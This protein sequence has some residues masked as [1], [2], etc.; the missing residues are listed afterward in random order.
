MPEP[1]P[2]A[3]PAAPRVVEFEPIPE[4]ARAFLGV[5]LNPLVQAASPLLLLMGQLRSAPASLDVS[6][7]RRHALDEIRRF[8]EQ[9]RRSGVRN[10]IVLAARYA[11]CAGLD[12]A[13]L[14][15]PS[16]SQ[17][18]WAQHPLLVALHREAWGGEKFFEMLDRVLVDPSRHI[19]LI[20]LQYLIL[21]LGFTGKYQMLERG[22]EKLADLQRNLHHA[23]RN[24]RGA[25]ASDLSLQW[26]GLEDQRN[27]LVRYVPWWVVV[28]AALVV[29]TIAFIVYYSKLETQAEPLHARLNEVG[30]G[31]F[32]VP[33]PPRPIKGPTLKQLLAPEEAAGLLLVTEE[34]ARTT[35]TFEGSELFRSGSAD[36]DPSYQDTLDR[37]AAALNKVPGRVMVVGHT[38]DQPIRSLRFSDNIELSRERAVSVANDLKRT[39]DNAARLTWRGVGSSQ[40]LYRPESDPA[41]RARNRRVEIIHLSEG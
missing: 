30:I 13:V 14:S 24:Q 2:F 36:V 16:G 1:S 18:E 39:I 15:T 5:G 7:L 21:A 17:S 12:E 4:A 10:E 20:E 33:P 31:D 11:L 3:R 23:I 8:E 41:N 25:A 29:L 38:D 35:I 19:D 37:V 9:A 34:G 32:A 6:G 28:A 26:R 22:H 27:R 40:P